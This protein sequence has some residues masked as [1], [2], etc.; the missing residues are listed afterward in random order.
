MFPRK[1]ARS[2]AIG[3]AAIAV[4]IGAY[5]SVRRERDSTT[6]RVTWRCRSSETVPRVEL[7][8]DQRAARRS[9]RSAPFVTKNG[10]HQ[11]QVRIGVRRLDGI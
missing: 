4:A 5:T 8:G 11:R 7:T 6:P 3:T 9:I 10:G 1:L 2:I